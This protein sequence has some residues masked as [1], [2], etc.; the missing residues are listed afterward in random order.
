LND[1]ITYLS[2]KKYVETRF[3]GCVWGWDISVR[4][5]GNQSKGAGKQ[6]HRK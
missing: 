4:G 2:K 6:A 1:I 3:I 5:R